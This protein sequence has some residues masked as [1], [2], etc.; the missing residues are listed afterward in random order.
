MD[1]G[2][3]WGERRG[4]RGTGLINCG[5]DRG[6]TTERTGISSSG[7]AQLLDE[8]ETLRNILG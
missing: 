6:R 8:L 1:G 5:E 4:G 3:E 7:S 2:K